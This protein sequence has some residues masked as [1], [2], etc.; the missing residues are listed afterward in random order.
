MEIGLLVTDLY[1]TNPQFSIDVT[2]T[3]DDGKCAVIISLMQKTE[4]MQ[5]EHSI[6]FILFKVSLVF[7][8]NIVITCLKV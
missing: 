7:L 1:W 5:K 3:G 4:D 2:E 6:N 8:C